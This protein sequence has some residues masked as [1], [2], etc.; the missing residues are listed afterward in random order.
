MIYTSYSLNRV[1]SEPGWIWWWC[2]RTYSLKGVG[3][4]R[5][6][7]G[8]R[9]GL[10]GV[11]VG[12]RG[13][14]TVEQPPK[15]FLL[16]QAESVYFSKKLWLICQPQQTHSASTAQRLHLFYRCLLIQWPCLKASN[17]IGKKAPP[18]HCNSY[19]NQSGTLRSHILQMYPH[20]SLT[21]V[22]G[23][24]SVFES[25]IPLLLIGW[26]LKCT[27]ISNTFPI[28]L[29]ESTYPME[30]CIILYSHYWTFLPTWAARL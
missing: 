27:N 7:G 26:D 8:G 18:H 30:L 6:G 10:T 19:L 24:N 20:V 11:S 23:D 1:C 13:W 3:R 5:K 28:T 16:C 25:G 29:E 22:Y 21:Y 15:A 17:Y 12:I 14:A 2:L 4:Y 9:E